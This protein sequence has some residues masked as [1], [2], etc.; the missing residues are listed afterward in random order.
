MTA[1]FLELYGGGSGTQG[2]R[3]LQPHPLL[4]WLAAPDHCSQTQA[5][6]LE[7][8]AAVAVD[9]KQTG[10]TASEAKLK[11][12]DDKKSWKKSDKASE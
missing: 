1:R 11:G 3:R 9:G 8:S 2:I 10:K 7:K 6:S 5:E 4:N 12:K